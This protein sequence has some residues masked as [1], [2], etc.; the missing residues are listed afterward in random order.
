MT[1]HYRPIEDGRADQYVGPDGNV[2]ILWQEHLYPYAFGDGYQ[3]DDG[4]GISAFEPLQQQ[5]NI[6]DRTAGG[7]PYDDTH[8][9]NTAHF[10]QDEDGE[11]VD[12]LVVIP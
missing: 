9:Y 4:E 8:P 12:M 3:Y 11:W 10:L 2:C 7:Y 1:I 5:D 6:P